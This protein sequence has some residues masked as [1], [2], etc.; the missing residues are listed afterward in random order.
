MLL[1]GLA[2]AD[3]EKVSDENLLFVYTAI[4]YKQNDEFLAPDFERTTPPIT[5]CY[6]SQSF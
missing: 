4:L 3:L 6:T 1:E 2:N 5:I